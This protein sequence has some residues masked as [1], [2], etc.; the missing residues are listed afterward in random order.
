MSALFKHASVV[1]VLEKNYRTYVSLHNIAIPENFSLKDK[2]QSIL[3]ESKFDQKRA[4][5]MDMDDF[6]THLLVPLQTKL[7]I[8]E[9]DCKRRRFTFDRL[10]LAV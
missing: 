5:I 8:K 3:V 9:R 4:R 7:N 1:T 10:H 6:I 2:A